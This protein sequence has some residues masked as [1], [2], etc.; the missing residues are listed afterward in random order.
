MHLQMAWCACRRSARHANVLLT[1]EVT[2]KNV[3]GTIK[4]FK[5]GHQLK[6][7]R[8]YPKILCYEMEVASLYIQHVIC[9][10]F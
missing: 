7:T 9:F 3:T 8:V 2:G 1:G 4:V 10:W 5:K 6:T